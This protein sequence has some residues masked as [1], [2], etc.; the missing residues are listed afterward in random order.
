[1]A[2]RPTSPTC[3]S[4]WYPHSGL[5]TFSTGSDGSPDIKDASAFYESL[6]ATWSDPIISTPQ[7]FLPAV[8]VDTKPLTV[9]INQGTG[10]FTTTSLPRLVY[11]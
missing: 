6:D 4:R 11:S 1:M 3:S 5:P 8:P 2:E 10:T 7:V 9:K